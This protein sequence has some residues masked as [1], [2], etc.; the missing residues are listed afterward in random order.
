MFNL[1]FL[2]VILLCFAA[3]FTLSAQK[4]RNGRQEFGLMIGGSNYFGDIAPE[5]VFKETK[6]A[7]GIFF[8]NNHSSFFSSKYFLNY[9]RISGSDKNFKANQYR[10][11][12]FFSDIYEL[13][14]DLEFNFKPFGMNVNDKPTTTYV[15]A[16]F[17]LFFFNPK[18]KLAN[19]D[20]VSLQRFGTEGQI[21]NDKRKYALI[22]PAL[23]LGLGYKFN[24]GKK[25]D[26]GAEIGFR[27]TFTDYLDDTKGN[28]TD[29]AAL[30]AKQGGTAVDL[31]QPQTTQGKPPIDNGTMR[32]DSHLKDWYFVMGITISFRNVTTFCHHPF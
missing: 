2:F 21:L 7:G 17:N 1:K 24:A 3:E 16:G 28:Y 22:Q 10:N 13:G 31:S 5:I 8:K 14:Y 12:S 26:I 11:I 15:F 9:A 32:G 27:K 23:N 4:Y 30:N 19:G 6:I 25:W 29:Y 18:T 20:R